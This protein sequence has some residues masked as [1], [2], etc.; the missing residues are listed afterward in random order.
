MR[1]CILMVGVMM[2]LF[3]FA[4]CK[5]QDNNKATL[6]LAESFM[7]ERPD[8]SL[9][10]LDEMDASKISDS[11][12]RA[13]YAL[14]KSIALDKNYIDTTTFDVLQPAIDYYIKN[15]TT[16]EKLKTHYYQGI[17]YGNA[18]EDDLAM[19]SFLEAMQNEEQVTDTLTLARVLVAQATLFYKQYRLTEFSENN[20]K[21]ADLYGKLGRSPQQ[22]KCYA[23]ALDG[24]TRVRN[25]EIATQIADIC[26]SIIEYDSTLKCQRVIQSL[27]VYEIS[28]GKEENVKEMIVLS[29]EL[30]L[31]DDARINLARA[32]TR[33]G[34][35]RMGLSYLNEARISPEDIFDSLTYWSV[36]TEILER[37]G[38]DSEA[39]E[40]FR[41][42]SRLLE[43]YH[44]KL[45]SNE[46][47]FSEKKHEMEVE[48]M[49]RIQWKD[50]EI[51]WISAGTV[52]LIC[53]A[54]LLY[55]RYRYHKARQAI[56]ERTAG[57]LRREKGELESAKKEIEEEAAGLRQ[58]LVELEGERDR[59][60]DGLEKQD[61]TAAD[62]RRIIGKRLELL[63]GLLASEITKD[64]GH[65]KEYREYVEKIKK[66][67]KR[68][69][70]EI[71]KGLEATY[72]GFFSEL[73]AL[74]LTDKEI[75][76]VCLY[77]IGL[78]GKEIGSYLKVAGHYNI[79]SEIRHKL[80]L[81]S[82][83]E[84]LGPYL[85]KMM[86]GGKF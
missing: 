57:E 64:T 86:G 84:N 46:L 60:K 66:D 72:P 26:K 28:F 48:N 37:M 16:N 80:G 20:I 63:N 50:E 30:G 25:K 52:L 82:N 71:R 74:D 9:S 6:D 45:F 23:R 15:G 7:E 1:D 22:L 27:L 79:S 49:K 5:Q 59:L 56:A 61:E 78:R 62:M 68:F 67:R 4:G 70:R 40:A 51:M 77:A 3:I 43:T 36:K 55:Y 10:I 44:M 31:T 12:S 53:L 73:K 2:L 69:L 19:Q 8:S 47:L 32:Y 34:E 58:A 81:D 21:A 83:G 41:N 75:D 35:P 85:R 54:G 13:R 14:L 65:A 39:L 38:D 42:Y 76:Y 33:I 24:Q 18:G 29:Q 11:R 17:I